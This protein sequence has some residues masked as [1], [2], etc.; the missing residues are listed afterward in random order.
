[1]D[2]AAYLDNSKR[3]DIQAYC[4]LRRNPIVYSVLNSIARGDELLGKYEEAKECYEK[5]MK[6]YP[7]T[8]L[9]VITKDELKRAQ[10]KVEEKN[11]R[12]T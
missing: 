7:G 6:L 5:I 12:K 4:S 9:E 10:E 11:K 2:T 8:K 1:M 3:P